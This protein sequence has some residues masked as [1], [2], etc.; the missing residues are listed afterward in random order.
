MATTTEPEVAPS[1]TRVMRKSSELMTMAPFTADVAAQ[2][3]TFAGLRQV[4]EEL[5]GRGF[6][7]SELSMGM[8]N[9]FETAV[10]EGATMVRLGTVLFGER[11]I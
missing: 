9:D 5:V 6:R 4:R 8:T 11:S 7:L 2:R 1:G 3:R 10:E